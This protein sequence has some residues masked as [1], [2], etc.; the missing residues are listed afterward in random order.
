MVYLPQPSLIMA[1]RILIIEDDIDILELLVYLFE[2]EGYQVSSFNRAPEA[3]EIIHLL[4]D[5]I[6]LDVNLA[7]SA[8]REIRFVLTLKYS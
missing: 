2:N 4:P 5:V 8:K 6:L 3:E 7:G 1:K